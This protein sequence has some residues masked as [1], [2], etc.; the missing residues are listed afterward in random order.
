MKKK[1]I[2]AALLYCTSYA[3]HPLRHENI[4]N[5]Y[6]LFGYLEQEAILDLIYS[7]VAT[8]DFRKFLPMEQRL[9][10]VT[11]EWHE[12]RVIRQSKIEFLFSLLSGKGKIRVLFTK[13]VIARGHLNLINFDKITDNSSFS[14]QIQASC[15]SQDMKFPDRIVIDSNSNL[16][17]NIFDMIQHGCLSITYDEVIAY[18]KKRFGYNPQPHIDRDNELAYQEW[19]E[20]RNRDYAAIYPEMSALALHCHNHHDNSTERPHYCTPWFPESDD[21]DIYEI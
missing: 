10:P 21:S 18:Y 6:H 2:V 11:K 17:L 16:L 15:D 4:I 12:K 3:T 7:K 20:W 9:Q 8:Q 13:P 5:C 14:Y 1:L 19:L